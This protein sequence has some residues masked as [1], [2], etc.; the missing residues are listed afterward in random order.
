MTAIEKVSLPGSIISLAAFAYGLDHA[1]MLTTILAVLCL[2]TFVGMFV[3]VEE[4]EKFII[5]HMPSIR[6]AG[7]FLA[8]GIGL[9]VL[10]MGTGIQNLWVNA[11]A[12]C[13]CAVILYLIHR[14]L[15]KSPTA[16]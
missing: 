4:M 3:H 7:A 15:T 14:L 8:L 11:L 1:D 6:F 12:I 16:N 2:M 5:K 10:I 13:A 9:F